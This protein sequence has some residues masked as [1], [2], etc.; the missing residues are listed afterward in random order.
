MEAILNSTSERVNN[1]LSRITDKKTNAL[2]EFFATLDTTN[3]GKNSVVQDVGFFYHPSP[4][5][6]TTTASYAGTLLGNI[7]N[8]GVQGA[9]P[10]AASSLLP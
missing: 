6:I 3:G 4:L 8:S 10:F 7:V 1:E 9:S 2:N 5:P